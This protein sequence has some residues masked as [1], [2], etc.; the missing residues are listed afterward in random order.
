MTD[1]AAFVQGQINFGYGKVAEVLGYN[2]AVYRSSAADN[3]LDSSH[4]LHAALR[5]TPNQKGGFSKPNSFGNAIWWSFHDGSQTQ[6]GDHLVGRNNTFFVASQQ[7]LLPIQLV[8]CNRVLTFS[9]VAEPQGKG[10]QGYSGET[11]GD[12]P[13]Y[14]VGWPASVLQGSKGEH[15]ATGLP[16]DVKNPWWLALLSASSGLTIKLGDV[17]DDEDGNTYWVHQAEPTDLGWRL[18]LMQVQP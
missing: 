2:Y 12:A 4:L 6:P 9:R 10:F 7:D 11:S 15:N 1:F 17:V 16:L 18:K 3:P 8:Q 5:V 14:M 13:T